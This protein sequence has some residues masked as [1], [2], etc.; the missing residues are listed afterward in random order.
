MKKLEPRGERRQKL[1]AFLKQA[2]AAGF[3]GSRIDLW[4]SFARNE[5]ITGKTK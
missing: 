4:R 5:P 2:R 3:K 1:K